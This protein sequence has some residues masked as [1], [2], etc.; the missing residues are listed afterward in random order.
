MQPD[1]TSETAS[2]ETTP[3]RVYAAVLCASLLG[4]LLFRAFV[5]HAYRIP[6]GSMESTLLVGDYLLAERLTFGSFVELPIAEKALF[7]WPPLRQP[8]RGEVIIFRS[9]GDPGTEIVKRCVGLPGDTVEVVDNIVK[10]N[11]VTSDP[12]FQGRVDTAHRVKTEATFPVSE[13]RAV[14]RARNFGPHVVKT[15]HIFVMGDNRTN[16]ED[17][18]VHGDVSFEALTGR[19]LFIYWSVNSHSASLNPFDSIRW[20]RIGKRIH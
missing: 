5:I 16:S 6:S 4:A 17:S 20:E 10:V 13:W 2:K 15:G 9:W 18:R 12:V 8:R 1:E 11:G 14:E 7:R 3:W 19:P